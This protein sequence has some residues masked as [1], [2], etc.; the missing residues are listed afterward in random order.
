MCVTHS[1]NSDTVGLSLNDCLHIPLIFDGSAM[2]HSSC[3]PWKPTS[4]RLK[5]LVVRRKPNRRKRMSRTDVSC[6]VVYMVCPVIDGD[7][8]EFSFAVS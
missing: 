2:N 8:S 5:V 7:L 1:E 3:V 6:L 4:R